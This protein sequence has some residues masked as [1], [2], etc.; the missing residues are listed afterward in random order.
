MMMDLHAWLS[1]CQ[2]LSQT[3]QDQPSDAVDTQVQRL[4]CDCTR[5]SLRIFAFRDVLVAFA[6]HQCTFLHHASLA[7]ICAY[8]WTS[9]SGLRP[10]LLQIVN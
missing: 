3:S 10:Q 7:P 6:A 9:V 5:L 2:V 8:P 1:D 4:S